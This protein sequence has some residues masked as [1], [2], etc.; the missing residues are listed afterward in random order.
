MRPLI[1]YGAYLVIALDLN[2]PIFSPTQYV[3]FKDQSSN[4]SHFNDGIYNL[5]ISLQL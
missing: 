2:T 4:E 1:G 5:L 3:Y